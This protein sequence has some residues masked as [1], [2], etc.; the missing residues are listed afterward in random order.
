LPALKPAVLVTVSVVLAAVPEAGVSVA[1]IV[2]VPLATVR[3]V[4][5]G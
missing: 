3:F 5:T 4:V 2:D 1:S